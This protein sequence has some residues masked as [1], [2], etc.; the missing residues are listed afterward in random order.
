LQGEQR[1]YYLVFITTSAVFFAICS[2][3]GMQLQHKKNTSAIQ[4][5]KPHLLAN[6]WG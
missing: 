5:K 3:L 4:N 6:G 2:A 1:Y